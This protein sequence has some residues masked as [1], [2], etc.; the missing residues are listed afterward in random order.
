MTSCPTAGPEATTPD[1]R[2]AENKENTA[3]RAAKSSRL[4]A[5]I[6]LF[7]PWKWRRKKKSDRFAQTS[8][9]LERRIS[10][11]ASK[12]DLIQRGVLLPDFVHNEQHLH[13]KSQSSV[14]TSA[15]DSSSVQREEPATAVV[16][17]N[18]VS[19]ATSH[20]TG[21]VATCLVG[22]NPLLRSSLTNRNGTLVAKDDLTDSPIGHKSGFESGNERLTTACLQS[23]GSHLLSLASHSPS[24]AERAVLSAISAELQLN[25]LESKSRS[26]SCPY[27]IISLTSRCLPSQRFEVQC[28]RLTGWT[29][30]SGR[31]HIR[32]NRSDS[33]APYVQ[34]Y[35][36]HHVVHHKRLQ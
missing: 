16:G 4:S 8:R 31:S 22:M 5:L 2:L 30:V 15:D 11:R 12:E 18:R 24:L 27:H 7:A 10:V 23:R 28:E 9:S 25:F 6:R 21:A 13:S 1:V 14:T 36:H 26:V 34:R 3:V 33:S 19:P 17:L 29:R 32:R 35:E 20:L